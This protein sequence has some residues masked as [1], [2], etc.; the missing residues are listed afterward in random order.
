MTA[1]IREPL[2]A[3]LGVELLEVRITPTAAHDPGRVLVTF[4]DPAADH[5]AALSLSPLAVSVGRIATGVYRV[6]L[7]D[8]T[9]VG[10][11]VDALG[12]LPGVVAAQPD[13]LVTPGRTTNDPRTSDQW[14]LA[15]IGAPAA[16]DHSVSTG[17][18]VVAV[19]DTGVDYAHPDLAANMWRNPR[20]VPGNGRDDDGNGFVDD[21]FGADFRDNDGDPRDDAGHGTH[22]AG[23]IGARGGN[24]VGVTGVAWITQIMALRF[25]SASGG[26]T[27]DAVRAID[28]AVAN[29][30]K[31]INA[32][33]G[34]TTPDPALAAAIGRA[35]A[36][37]AI[38]VVAA[39]NGATNIDAGP[40]YPANYARQFDNVV[41]VAATDRSDNLAGFS[42]SGA[43]TVAVAA[44]GVSILSTLPNGRYGSMSGTSMA[45]PFVSG[46]V[47]LLW[48][49]NPGWSYQTV[50]ARL[51]ESAAEMPGLA[52]RVAEG[53]LDL[54]RMLNFSPPAPPAPPSADATG[55]RVV[56][57]SLEGPRAG[58]FDRV[59]V[60][61][62]EP[63][64][65]ATFTTADATGFG[66]FG[67][68]GI[69]AVLSV[70]GKNNT[71]FVLMFS[72]SQTAT[73]TYSVAIGPDVRD[74]AGNPMDQNG[75][76][77]R[78]EAA[79][80]F[81]ATATLGGAPAV[82]PAPPAGAVRKT[83]D[84]PALPRTIQD[85][86][87]T[88]I[89][90]VVTEDFRVADLDVQL[91]IT[92]ART[93]DLNIR[94]VA[95]DGRS[96]TLFNRRGTGLANAVFDDTGAV[97]PDQVLALFNGMSARGVWSVQVFDLA[98]G[99]V[100][101]VNSVRLSF[102]PQGAGRP[103]GVAASE[104]LALDAAN[105]RGADAVSR[106]AVL[107]GRDDQPAQSAGLTT[108][109]PVRVGWSW[110]GE[111]HAAAPVHDLTI[112]L[113]RRA[114]L[115]L[116]PVVVAPPEDPWADLVDDFGPVRV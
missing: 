100:G 22:V 25:M 16:W 24:G 19:I 96:V 87:T 10:A 5:F 31:V 29:G 32:S 17:A 50:I 83:Y 20:E 44:P 55:P 53:R 36:A 37:G 1:P 47:A 61:F 76:G 52:G 13:Y 104:Y 23:I 51:R 73:G 69:S 94:I 57:A 107:G 103:A 28:Y 78:G 105:L 62:S 92:H 48:G 38:V 4:A 34:G 72:R 81:T 101:S 46:A 6:D 67:P 45:T 18:V 30:A 26:Y 85:R 75:N 88:R 74:V 56:S 70:A 114:G 12:R 40:F 54:G 112:P 65:P 33:W 64:A 108:A 21:V 109:A 113:A 99:V 84:A 27:S 3:H 97:R 8:G 116:V 11:A 43:A 49:A 95:P 80:R 102:A 7:A 41:T 86:R 68:F 60:R 2:R 90:I 89:D 110:F 115:P 58:A 9:A 91:T 42:N 14:G 106:E 66:P 79:D 98:D 63:I 77:T 71:E 93:Q 59:R 111:P 82:P 15:K 39:G 35:R